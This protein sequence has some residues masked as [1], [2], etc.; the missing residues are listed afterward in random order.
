[1]TFT[2]RNQSS[3][4]IGKSDKDSSMKIF[5]TILFTPTESCKTPKELTHGELGIQMT[6]QHIIECY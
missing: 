1:M 2:G 5:K 3:A 6:A 4:L